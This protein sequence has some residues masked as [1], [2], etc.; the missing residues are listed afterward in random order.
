MLP[1][2]YHSPGLG[3]K[4]NSEIRNAIKNLQKIPGLGGGKKKAS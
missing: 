4:R 1:H 2:S 3:G